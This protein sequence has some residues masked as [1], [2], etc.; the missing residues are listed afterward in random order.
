[1]A[2]AAG[3]G[4]G[5]GIMG[6]ILGGVG[7]IMS[8]AN[9]ER[10]SLPEPGGQEARLRRLAQ[11]QLLAG[12]QQ[13]LGGMALYNQMAPLLMGMLPGMSYVPGGGGPESL[14]GVTGA[15]TGGQGGLGSYQ[16]ALRLLQETQARNQQLEDLKRQRKGAKGKAA[17]QAFKPQ[18]QALKQA[19]K[20]AP[21]V[22][23]AERRMYQGATQVDP[24]I[25]DIRRG[26]PQAAPGG[27]GGLD[28]MSLGAI[29]GMMDAEAGNEPDLL[30]LFR[31]MGG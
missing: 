26:A 31:G 22:Q 3:V 5:L 15:A 2:G 6:G 25:Y 14:G 8:A 19:K 29:R 21:R 17:K 1:M 23:D 20:A 11:N 9:Y 18:I 13:T 27:G 7:D 16:D 12:G 30:A 28:G 4:A 10:P 24:S